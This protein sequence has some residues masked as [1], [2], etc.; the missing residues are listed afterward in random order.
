MTITK[1]LPT[2]AGCYVDGHW[3][4]YGSARMIQVAE[5]FGYEDVEV[6]A[7]AEKHLSSMY[8]STSDTLT[9]DE[10][11]ILMD[12]LDVAEQWLNEHVAPEG[13]S[14]GWHDGEYFLWSNE[15]WENEA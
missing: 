7:I 11:D 10:H 6:G 13:Y 3:G 2:D 9:D 1:A 14:F 15:E 8:P 5:Q 12:A 4:Q